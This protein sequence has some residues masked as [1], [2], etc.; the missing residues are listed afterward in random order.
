M[1]GKTLDELFNETGGVGGA[2]STASLDSI[3]EK[4]DSDEFIQESAEERVSPVSLYDR[5][6]LGYGNQK[7]IKS[8]LQRKGYEDVKFVDNKGYVKKDSKWYPIDTQG[9]DFGDLAELDKTIINFGGMLIGGAGG[10]AVGTLGGPAAPVTVPAGAL[11]GAAAGQA[12]T[13]GLMRARG[14]LMGVYDPEPGE[15][16]RGLGKAAAEGAIGEAGGRVLGWA[17]T[18]AVP[19]VYKTV[20][21]TIG[22]YPKEFLEKIG[23]NPEFIKTINEAGKN[24]SF[25]TDL[26]TKAKSA[27]TKM[28]LGMS[29]AYKKAQGEIG[30]K[31]KGVEVGLDQ[32][33][34][35]LK[36]EFDAFGVIEDGALRPENLFPRT[37]S[38]LVRR[39][40]KDI[41]DWKNFSVEGTNLLRRK[42]ANY[43]I[44]A[45]SDAFNTL[46]TK[47][48]N[49]VNDALVE[50]APEVGQM[51]KNWSA[52]KTLY[53][54]LEKDLAL[55]DNA[56]T[57]TAIN[58][59]SSVFS[60]KG[61]YYQELV[62]TLSKEGAEELYDDVIA[63]TMKDWLPQGTLRKLFG[64]YQ[65]VQN[66]ASTGIATALSASPRIAANITAGVSKTAQ[67]IPKAVKENIVPG[68][69]GLIQ[70]IIRKIQD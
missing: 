4:Q 10:A 14:K 61:N 3:Y 28:R 20:A 24:E 34:D 46:V 62:R 9:L 57:Q 47:A 55:G 65:A 18:K 27:A 25:A 6:K 40:V 50:V 38:A 31:Y 45:R 43:N 16:A 37:E 29:A 21:S 2:G 33:D 26:V 22:G 11:A 7:G 54:K 56:S 30:K 19:W 12:T 48:K 70:N 63:L 5:W 15:T 13:E 51:N 49:A 23:Q 36:A 67:A 41:Q 53:E 64:G 52:S 8:Y 44:P 68:I 17:F 69:K 59:L 39:M 60:K 42:I 32:I 1:P 58:R 66:P 35:K